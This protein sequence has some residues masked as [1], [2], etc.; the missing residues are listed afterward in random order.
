METVTTLKTNWQQL[1]QSSKT[2]FCKHICLKRQNIDTKNEYDNENGNV[3][4]HENNY[5]TKHQ[6]EQN[7]Q[8]RPARSP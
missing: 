4:Q 8:N 1:K 5:Q 6:N 2:F 3:H 7:T